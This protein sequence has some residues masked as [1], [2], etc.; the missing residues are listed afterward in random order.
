MKLKIAVTAL[1]LLACFVAAACAETIK[2][3]EGNYAPLG[4][5]KTIIPGREGPGYVRLWVRGDTTPPYVPGVECAPRGSGS[6]QFA[7]AGIS[8]GMLANKDAKQINWFK[9]RTACYE[10]DGAT[11][12]PPTVR[13][14]FYNG[15]GG[16]R[17]CTYLPWVSP[18]PRGTTWT[19]YEYDLLAGGMWELYISNYP[20]YNWANLMALYPE[21]R[22]CTDAEVASEGT[23]GGQSFVVSSG[24]RDSHEMQF[25]NS[26]RGMVDWVEIGFT[27]GTFYKLDFGAPDCAMNNRAAT[28]PIIGTMGNGRYFRQVIFGRIVADPAPGT[29]YFYADDGAGTLVLVNAVGH[30][31]SVGQYVRAAGFARY[32]AVPP[33]FDCTATDITELAP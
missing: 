8:T 11:F 23:P 18:N 2:I 24:C 16:Y 9:L 3:H 20:K 19:F 32:G 17:S 31:R 27:D 10:G 29:D 12:Q 22:F 7:W 21:A 26:A 1:C 4:W 15:A 28:D 13:I 5:K 14:V 30:G 33:V 25:F 6:G